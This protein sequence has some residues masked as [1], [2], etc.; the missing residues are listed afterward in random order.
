[1]VES[2]V[3][4]CMIMWL[5]FRRISENPFLDRIQHTSFHESVRSLPNVNLE[6]R[7]I[8]FC[9]KPLTDFARICRL[10]KPFHSFD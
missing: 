9:T 10:E 8:E 1:M 7:Y 3:R 6:R 4:Y 5:P 2:G